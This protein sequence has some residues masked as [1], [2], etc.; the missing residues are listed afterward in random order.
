MNIAVLSLF[1][2]TILPVGAYFNSYGVVLRPYSFE[3]KKGRFRVEFKVF[4]LNGVWGGDVD[5]SSSSWG[6]GSPLMRRDLK[7]HSLETCM[8]SLWNY[9]AKRV[10]QSE[11]QMLPF[12]EA[13]KCKW[14]DTEDKLSLFSIDDGTL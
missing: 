10:S 13:S 8:R 9:V 6:M 4:S 11:P 5:I 3:I 14:N 2:E 12:I 1:I 7:Y